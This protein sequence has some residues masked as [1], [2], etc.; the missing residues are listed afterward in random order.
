MYAFAGLSGTGKSFLARIFAQVTGL[1]HFSSDV[2]RKEL[3][4]LQ[5]H[6]SSA[7]IKGG[8]YTEE[9]S[10]RTYG[11]LIQ[12]ASEYPDAILDAT[13]TSHWQRNMLERAGLPHIFI[14]CQA[15][16]AVVTNRIQQRQNE[17]DNPSEAGLDIYFLQQKRFEPFRSHECCM[18]VDTFSQ[19]PWSAVISILEVAPP[20]G[21]SSE[22]EM[23]MNR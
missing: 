2:I 17:P 6:E 1:P 19:S 8:I 3:A 21:E 12:R 13:F 11:E 15:P 14:L 22:Q 10:R 5:P 23:E 20:Q 7:S 18:V 4:G 16:E 9:L